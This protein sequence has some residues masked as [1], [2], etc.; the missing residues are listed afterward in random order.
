MCTAQR[1]VFVILLGFFLH[2]FSTCQVLKKQKVIKKKT[3]LDN[4]FKAT[5][6]LKQI[7][8]KIK[9]DRRKEKI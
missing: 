9:K 2:S 8:L 1:D 4:Y 5:C 3:S 6:F 7:K